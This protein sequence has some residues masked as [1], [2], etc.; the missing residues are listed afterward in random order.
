VLEHH[1]LV[2][3]DVR[4]A[5][6]AVD[7]DDF[8]RGVDRHFDVGREGGAAE[9]DRGAVL[10]DGG[11]IGLGELGDLFIAPLLHRRIHRVLEVVV[12]LDE[13]HQFSRAMVMA[14]IAFEGAAAGGVDRLIEESRVPH[15]DELAAIHVVAF[16]D[17]E[18]RLAATGVVS[19][20]VKVLGKRCLYRRKL[21]QE[22]FGVLDVLCFLDH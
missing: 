1:P 19:R 21:T 18:I 17:V 5:L 9:T 6:D 20:D 15:A 4:F 7:Q 10:E 12:N 14:F 13:I 2:G 22:L 3:G 16:F 11:D 8:D